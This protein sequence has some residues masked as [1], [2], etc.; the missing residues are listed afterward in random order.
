M[1]K[2]SSIIAKILMLTIFLVCV[3]IAF[4][5]CENGNI[6]INESISDDISN[7]NSSGEEDVVVSRRNC[8][9]SD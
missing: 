9:E 8:G 6:E 7:I 4:V 3:T 1:K 2:I 5:G